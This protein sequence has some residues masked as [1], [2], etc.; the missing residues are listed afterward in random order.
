MQGAKEPEQVPGGGEPVRTD[1][2]STVVH[3]MTAGASVNW[4]RY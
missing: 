3:D 2:G 4:F 1:Q